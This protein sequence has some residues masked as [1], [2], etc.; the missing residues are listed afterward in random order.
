MLKDLPDEGLIIGLK[1]YDFRTL[2][3]KFYICTYIYI[4]I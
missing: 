4:Y 2:G 1:I 3:Q